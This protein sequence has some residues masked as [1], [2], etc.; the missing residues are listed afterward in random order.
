[1]GALVYTR[2]LAG[3]VIVTSAA[4]V[5]L[6]TVPTGHTYVVKAIAAVAISP[7]VSSNFRVGF[8]S[9]VVMSSR[10]FFRVMAPGENHYA[11]VLIPMTAGESLYAA[12][13]TTPG[14]VITLA[15]FDFIEA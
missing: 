6:F 10:I 1:M 2:R 14:V 11:L 3:P 8:S 9:G 13:D 7:T 15:G 12:S 5:T 4:N